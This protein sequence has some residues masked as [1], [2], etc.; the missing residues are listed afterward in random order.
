VSQKAWQLRQSNPRIMAINKD[1]TAT[2]TV[3]AMPLNIN[4]K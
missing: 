3:S 4:G 1:S 2:S